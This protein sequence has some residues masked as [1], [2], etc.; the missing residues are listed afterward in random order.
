MISGSVYENG[1]IGDKDVLEYGWYRTFAAGTQVSEKIT[2]VPRYRAD[3]QMVYSTNVTWGKTIRT[4]RDN[5]PSCMVLRDSFGTQMFDIIAERMN[6]TIYKGMWDYT[7]YGAELVAQ[8]PD[9]LIYILAEWNLD[10]IVYN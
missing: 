9:Y 7:Y 2:D 1:Y 4:N 8:K 3:T 6:K 10:S 5:L